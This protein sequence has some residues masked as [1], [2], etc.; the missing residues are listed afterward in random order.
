MEGCFGQHFLTPKQNEILQNFQ[1]KNFT[2]NLIKK[3]PDASVYEKLI[4]PI[5]I[6]NKK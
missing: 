1:T 4:Q 5:T 3:L 2:Q 6:C